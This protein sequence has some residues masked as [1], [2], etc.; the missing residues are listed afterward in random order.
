MTQET[1][2]SSPHVPIVDVEIVSTTAEPA[3]QLSIAALASALGRAFES[4]PGHT[5]V[6]LRFLPANCYAENDTPLPAEAL[7]VF[8]T[9]L[10][11]RPPQGAELQ[12]QVDAVTQAVA[13][14]LAYPSE[15]VHIGYAPAAAGREAFGGKVV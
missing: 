10:Q 13:A 15:R 5:W 7:P 1:I 9:V 14:W 11:A 12:A 4:P 3:P 6:R 2:L 8:V